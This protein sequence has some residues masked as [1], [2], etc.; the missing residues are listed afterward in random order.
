MKGGLQMSQG[1]THFMQ[2]TR[3]LKIILTKD[4]F[5][6]GHP[7]FRKGLNWVHLLL[8]LD[9]PLFQIICGYNS[10]KKID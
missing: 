4:P 9:I 6:V 10:T 2:P 1:Q 3:A 7:E 5:S 8:K